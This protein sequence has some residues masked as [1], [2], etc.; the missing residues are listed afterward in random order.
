MGYVPGDGPKKVYLMILNGITDWEVKEKGETERREPHAIFG[1]EGID[2]VGIVL[3]GIVLVGIV[4]VSFVVV[5]I[6]LGAVVM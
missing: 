4:E 3:V 6:V 5:G 2:L 1:E